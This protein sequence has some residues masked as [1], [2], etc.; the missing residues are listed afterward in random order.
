MGILLPARLKKGPKMN[1]PNIDDIRTNHRYWA[2]ECTRLEGDI[3]Q[4]RIALDKLEG[5]HQ[6]ALLNT[7]A[8]ANQLKDIST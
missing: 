4:S 3:L 8:L 5:L 7:I 1:H 2:G 6:T